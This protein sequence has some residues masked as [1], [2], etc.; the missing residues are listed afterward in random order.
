MERRD[1][2]RKGIAI[3][4]FSLASH[5]WTIN[6]VTRVAGLGR[7]R[8]EM[9]AKKIVRTLDFNF[10]LKSLHIQQRDH[11]RT[12]PFDPAILVSLRKYYYTESGRFKCAAPRGDAK[13][14]TS[15]TKTKIESREIRGIKKKVIH[16]NIETATARD[17]I[18]NQR[19]KFFLMF[20]INFLW[21]PKNHL[22]FR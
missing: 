12:V 2:C 11:L 1:E 9:S 18:V 19:S 6:I 8:G 16:Q 5:A 20:N 7:E 3:S 15:Q 13:A 21:F 17:E 10:H 14:R 22:Q 4:V